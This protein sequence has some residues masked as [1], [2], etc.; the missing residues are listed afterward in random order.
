MKFEIGKRYRWN[1]NLSDIIVE[2]VE[3]IDSI[4]KVK[5]L[6]ILKQYHNDKVGQTYTLGYEYYIV[7]DLL[8]KLLP[9]QDKV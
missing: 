3:I 7:D 4:V 8:V 2:C 6:Q 9:N 1:C 5:F